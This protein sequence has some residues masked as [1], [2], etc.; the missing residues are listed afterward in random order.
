MSTAYTYGNGV[1]GNAPAS[2]STPTLRTT[3]AKASVYVGSRPTRSDSVP[4]PALPA[5]LATPT[6]P[7][8]VAP[9][10]ADTPWSTRYATWCT[11]SIWVATLP[12]KKT[13]PAAQ[14]RHDRSAVAGV[15]CRRPRAATRETSDG[16]ASTRA[17]AAASR[18]RSNV[19]GRIHT[20]TTMPKIRIA[21]R[22][23]S[24]SIRSCTNGTSAKIPTPSP[25]DDTPIAVPTRPGNHARMS[26]TDGTQPAALTPRAARSPIAT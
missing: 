14:N 20:A 7:T 13:T 17:G 4:Q 26:T 19:A 24:E 21:H 10:R 25:A 12:A 23:P 1:R 9:T 5:T 16:D 15:Q 11:S 3:Q 22:Q 2:A 18:T 6:M 8:T